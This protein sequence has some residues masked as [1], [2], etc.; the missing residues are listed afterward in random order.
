LVHVRYETAH[1]TAAVAVALQHRVPIVTG[2]VPPI[3]LLLATAGA[4][5]DPTGWLGLR[6]GA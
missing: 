1:A 6:D 4:G 2:T 3:R 5:G